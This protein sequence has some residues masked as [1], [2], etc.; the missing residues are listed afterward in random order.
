M[1]FRSGKPQ[2]QGKP[3][4]KCFECDSHLHT[5]KHCPHRNSGR[6]LGERFPTKGVAEYLHELRERFKSAEQYACS[7]AAKK[8]AQYATHYNLRSQNKVFSVGKQVLILVPDTTANKTFSRWQGPATMIVK[9]S[10]YSYIVELNGTKHHLH[11][12]KLRKFNYHVQRVTCE[13]PMTTGCN[14]AIIFEKTQI[15]VR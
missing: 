8:Q 12:N 11:A 14:S 10:P 2:Q 3:E 13:I 7:H 5:I 6:K 4:R 9:K 15:L 1:K